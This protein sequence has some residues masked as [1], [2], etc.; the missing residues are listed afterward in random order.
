MAEF[1]HVRLK[2]TSTENV[3]NLL[4]GLSNDD[5]PIPE[6]NDKSTFI[7]FVA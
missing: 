2:L 1:W 5:E 4:C 7:S 6:H 3:F